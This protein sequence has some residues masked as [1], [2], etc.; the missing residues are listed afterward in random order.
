MTR[1][2]L[3]VLAALLVPAAPAAAIVGGHAPTRP[4][5]AMAVLQQDGEF[6]CGASLVRPRW[7]LTAA[8]CAIDDSGQPLD[9]T[10]LSFVLGRTRQS[11]DQ[12]EELAATRVVVNPK[13][14]D[15]T[16]SSHDV[17]VVELERD[18]VE[19]PIRIVTPEEKALWAPGKQATVIGWGGTFYP[20]IGGVNTTDDLMEVQLPMV[21]DGDCDQAYSNGFTGDFE[22]ETMVCAGDQTGGK[23]SCSGDSG[24]PLMVPDANRAMVLAGVVSWGFGCGYPTQ[25]GVYGRIGDHEL[26][27]WITAQVGPPPTPAQPTPPPVTTPTPAAPAK[28]RIGAIKHTAKKLKVTVR[29]TNRR[30]HARLVRR[31]VV[32]AKTARTGAGRLV[33]KL[34]RGATGRYRLEISA[35]GATGAHRSVAL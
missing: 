3:L 7:I 16:D 32:V 18:A 13:Y 6:V 22:P 34:P 17:A 27:D 9:P 5:P 21:A 15:P 25:Y 11:S 12:G 26:Y 19:A 24:G 28:L 33:L 2:L 20:G 4:Y 1:A 30:I 23:D 8:H 10:H 35:R 14:G 31:G 29:G